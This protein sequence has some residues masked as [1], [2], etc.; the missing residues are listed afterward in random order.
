[1]TQCPNHPTITTSPYAGNDTTISNYTT[2]G[3]NYTITYSSTNDD[4]GNN[5]MAVI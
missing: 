1:V 5:V 3:F 2:S 4:D